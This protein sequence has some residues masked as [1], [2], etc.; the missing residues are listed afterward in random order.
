MIHRSPPFKGFNIGIPIVIPISGKGFCQHGSKLA[1]EPEGTNEF[2]AG[3]QRV[4]I[5]LWGGA[6]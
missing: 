1:G 4:I 3:Y 6:I 5:G 2:L